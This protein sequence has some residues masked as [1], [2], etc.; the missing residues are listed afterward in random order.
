MHEVNMWRI[1]L[2]SEYLDFQIIILLEMELLLSENWFVFISMVNF[3]VLSLVL[4][5]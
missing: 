3:Q 2:E 1:S 5:K 4:I